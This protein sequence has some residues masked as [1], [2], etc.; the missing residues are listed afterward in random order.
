MGTGSKALLIAAGIAA[1][2]CGM[3]GAHALEAPLKQLAPGTV[4]SFTTADNGT[5]K[6]TVT[7]ME[8]VS[9]FQSQ[10]GSSSGR[11]NNENV[12]FGATLAE[13]RRET[14]TSSQR[15]DVAKLFPLKVGNSTS[16]GHA[17]SG[18][19]GPFAVMDRLE[20]TGTEKI[21]VP[22][23]TFETFVISTSMKD[24]NWWGQNTCWYAPEIGYCAKRKWRSAT[25]SSDWELTSVALP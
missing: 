6:V 14:M 8:G 9:I 11:D 16:S 23:G 7:K 24:S 13:S 2:G 15:E 25:T 5:V 3:P 17:G 4:F 1:I 12:G 19:R 21:T 10:E 18:P 22:A 20:V